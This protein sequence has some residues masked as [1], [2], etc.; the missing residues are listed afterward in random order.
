LFRLPIGAAR[1][2]AVKATT[3]ASALETRRVENV[4]VVR[5]HD[6]IRKSGVLVD[7]LHL[8]PGLTAVCC[9]VNAA[10]F[11]RSE[12]M[13]Q[14]SNIDGLWI[15]RIDHYPADA[16]RILQSDIGEGF[17]TVDGLVDA[18]AECRCLTVIRF[19]GADVDDIG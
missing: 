15:L 12:E 18:V 2:A 14:R 10:L 11:I 8:V 4:A 7:V 3:A 17:A 6:D 13:S 9:L 19:A 1:T 5:I 16:L